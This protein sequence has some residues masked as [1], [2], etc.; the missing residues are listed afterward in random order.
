MAYNWYGNFEEKGKSYRISTNR[1]PRHWY[2]YFYNHTFNSF[3]SQVG[4]GEG[5]AQDEMGRR[6]PLLTRRMVYIRDKKSGEW[7]TANGLPVKKE[8]VNFSCIHRLG[9]TTINSSYQGLDLSY[10]IFVPSQGNCELWSVEIKN[11]REEE[12][13]LSVIPYFSTDI[14][15]VYKP[16]GYQTNTGGWLSEE[17]ALIGRGFTNYG[18]GMRKGYFGFFTSNEKI[19]SYD[20]RRN[21]FIGVYGEESCPEALEDGNGCTGSS[22]IGEKLCFAIQNEM[23]LGA[24]ES[25]KIYYMA[26]ISFSRNEMKAMQKRYLNPTEW[27]R[28]FDKV[29]EQRSAEISGV[30]IETPDSFLNQAFNSFCKYETAM[31]SRWARVRHNGYR[32][33]VS[34]TE[35]LSC[36]N[37]TLAWENMKRILTYQYS[38]GYAPRTFLDGKIQDNY[39]ADC[40]VWIAM[41][42]YAIIM[43]T[44]KK[45]LL[46]EVVEYND[47]TTG[48]VY[49]HVKRSID[50]LFDFQGS[51]GLIRI[52]GG[53]W[54][55]CMNQAGL[56]GKGESVWLSIA[57]CRANECF[58]KLARLSGKEEDRDQA[59]QKRKMMLERIEAHGWDGNYYITAIDDWGNKIGSSENQEG[60][61]YLIPQLWAVL[62]GIVSDERA[63]AVLHEVETRLET[64]LGT[65]IISPAYTRLDSK[66]GSITEKPPGVHE[67]GG[68]YLHTMMWKLAVDSIMGRPEYVQRGIEKILPW[69]QKW[70]NTQGEPYSLYNSYF[71]KQT[72]YRYGT[73]G[74]S[75]RTAAGAWMV[76]SLTVYVFG[77]QPHMEGILLKPCLP[78]A[79]KTCRVVKVFR[80]CTYDIRYV[81]A[82]HTQEGRVDRIWIDGTEFRGTYLP[83]VENGNITVKVSVK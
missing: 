71:G 81:Q 69:N 54:N 82:D 79:W 70:A 20:C 44:G 60:S 41:A 42:V 11:N 18:D 45:E 32:D 43:E 35:C 53:D 76:K 78:P 39:F 5:M 63:E 50:Y 13:E 27:E 77:I 48:T 19:D 37:P 2:N 83:W 38:S 64:D 80:T 31:G 24:G 30:M 62:A 73:P 4:Y 65:S 51:H 56:M 23:V 1:T 40:A 8:Y 16:Q 57:W 6:L 61:M 49:E 3:S 29:R 15:G 72:D 46:E 52:W 74:Q 67:N 26:G 10:T 36:V 66:I 14:D 21:A 28:E 7:F 34:D 22:C 12:A 68:V 47:H 75:W 58:Q 17:N 59:E 33:I 9:S 55:D 25:K